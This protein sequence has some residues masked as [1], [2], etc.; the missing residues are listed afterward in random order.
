M[1]SVDLD[2]EAA[3]FSRMPHADK[4]RIC[5][6]LAARA[7]EIARSSDEKHRASYLAIAAEWEKLAG[8]MEDRIRHERCS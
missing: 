5:R 1:P 4:I 6:L 7:R 3:D 8:D 2:F